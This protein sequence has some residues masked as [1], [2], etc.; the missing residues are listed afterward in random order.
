MS[1]TNAGTYVYDAKLGKV[2]KR[3]DRI[4]KVSSRSRSASRE[5]SPAPQAGPCGRS[6]CGGGRCAG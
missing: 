5:T 3:S 1:K 6:A 4:P 2:V